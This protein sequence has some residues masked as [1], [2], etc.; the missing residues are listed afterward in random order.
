MNSNNETTSD[1]EAP[2]ETPH[3]EIA[4][5]GDLN[6]SATEIGEKLLEVEPGGECTFYFDSPGGNAYT[7]ISL[8]A[9]IKVRGLQAT[10]VVTGECSS[11]ALWPF[12]ACERRLVTPYSVLLF[13]PIRWQSEEHVGLAEAREWA[14]HFEALEQSMDQLLAG[15]LGVSYEQLR[16][17]AYPG[18]YLTGP[19]LA[20]AGVAE[21]I[22]LRQLPHLSA[23]TSTSD[24]EVEPR[25]PKRD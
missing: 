20:E 4:F 3:P 7:G 16:Q 18:R 17:W 23:S 9:L 19:E 21:M 13:H 5:F 22:P 8:L 25:S 10:G 11:A 14:R 1:S 24:E 12:A 2:G 6:D 15:E